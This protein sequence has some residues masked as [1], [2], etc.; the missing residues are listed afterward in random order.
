MLP[1]WESENDV[2]EEQIYS[3]AYEVGRLKYQRGR[4]EDICQEDE[5]RSGLAMKQCY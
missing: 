3:Y 4:S 5:E 1:Q 2:S